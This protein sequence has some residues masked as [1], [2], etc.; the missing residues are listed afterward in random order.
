MI[1]NNTV[2]FWQVLKLTN[3]AYGRFDL[4]LSW[5]VPSDQQK[6]HPSLKKDK[7]S[8]SSVCQAS[9]GHEVLTTQPFGQ[10]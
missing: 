4:H 10:T 9:N 2:H 1:A 6:H 5:V 3:K 7:S 8:I